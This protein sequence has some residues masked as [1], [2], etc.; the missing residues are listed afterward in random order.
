MDKTSFALEDFKNIQELIRFVDQKAGAVL[1]IYI[2]ILTTFIGIATQL[3]FINPF[4]LPNATSMIFS[5]LTFLS[6]VAIVGLMI[7]QIYYIIFEVIKP[8][9]AKNYCESEN[10]LFYFDHISNI[11]KSDFMKKFKDIHEQ[12]LLDEVT[13]Q[14]YEVANI[15]S[16]KSEKFNIVLRYLFASLGTLLAYTLFSKLI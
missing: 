4:K 6:G 8:K 2:F 15:L 16:V 7:F 11:K 1:V 10:C 5:C 14:I 12:D 9:K 3:N 13:S